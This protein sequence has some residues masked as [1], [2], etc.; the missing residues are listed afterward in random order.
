MCS[1][2]TEATLGT[3]FTVATNATTCLG[4]YFSEGRHP[5][6]IRRLWDR[7]GLEQDEE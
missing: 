5:H 4:A 2:F 3:C 6:F 7:R 1:Q